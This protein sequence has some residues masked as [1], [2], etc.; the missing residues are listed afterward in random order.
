[1]SVKPDQSKVNVSNPRPD[2]TV[3]PGQKGEVGGEGR[4]PA[5]GSAGDGGDDSTR[6][7]QPAPAGPT[8]KS[9]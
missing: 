9:R 8:K 5:A 7:G 4:G 3:G 6:S 1:M 2:P